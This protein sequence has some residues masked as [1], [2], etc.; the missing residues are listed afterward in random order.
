MTEKRAASP[1]EVGAENPR[2]ADHELGWR[3]PSQ[4]RAHK[5][6]VRRGDAGAAAQLRVL[7]LEENPEEASREWLPEET[8]PSNAP[9]ARA[10]PRCRASSPVHGATHLSSPR[11]LPLPRRCR[12]KPR[13][14]KSLT[15]SQKFWETSA[16]RGTSWSSTRRSGS[17]RISCARTYRRRPSLRTPTTPHPLSLCN[18]R[19]V[20]AQAIFRDVLKE[21]PQA[22]AARL[23]QVVYQ[24]TL[25]I[26][27]VGKCSSLR[28]ALSTR[29]AA[30]DMAIEAAVRDWR[31][32]AE[33]PDLRLAK[34]RVRPLLSG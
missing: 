28:H 31:F 12:P 7:F 20:A 17:R 14:W 34:C 9:P 30:F 23:E 24:A 32:S 4:L 27:L 29:P 8:L 3:H 19:P 26:L 25:P 18:H 2:L 11:P 15:H 6:A 16:R 1:T 10:Q 33:P 13:V 5:E 22:D 21:L